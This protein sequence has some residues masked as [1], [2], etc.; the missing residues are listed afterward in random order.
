MN[1]LLVNDDGIKHKNLM[2]TKKALEKF[3][4]VYIASPSS[5]RSG[6][7]IG[8]SIF[9]G[10]KYHVIDDSTIT[11]DGSPADCTFVGLYHF[12]FDT[13]D[14]VISG[15]N[16][17]KNESYDHLY[18]GTVGGVI[19]AALF[20]KKA[21]ALSTVERDT[22]DAVYSK[23]VL[24]MDYILKNKLLDVAPLLSVNYPIPEVEFKGFKVGSIDHT[25][26]DEHFRLEDGNNLFTYRDLRNEKEGT[27]RYLTNNGYF[28]I[29]ALKPSLLDEELNNK[30]KEVVEK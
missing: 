30:L 7:S 23:T 17:G 12:G 2:L 15:T 28:S 22:D 9:K 5:E 25:I 19:Q 14:I 18:S 4:K 13:I 10:T 6:A 16:S 21:I 20:H 29:T 8:I 27:D 3:G 26:C 11:V 1:F 24:A